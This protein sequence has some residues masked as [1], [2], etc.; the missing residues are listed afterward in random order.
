MLQPIL[1]KN[2]SGYEGA[3]LNEIYA[4]CL[5]SLYVFEENPSI[6]WEQWQPYIERAIKMYEELQMT[7]RAIRCH[8]FL[9]D[10]QFDQAN[11]E[12]VIEIIDGMTPQLSVMDSI[13]TKSVYIQ[14]MAMKSFALESLGR[15]QQAHAELDA[16]LQFSRDHIVL[17][18]YYWLLNT[19]AWLYYDEHNYE[20]A[21]LL[22][23]EAKPFIQ[24]VNHEGI[25]ME[26]ELTNIFLTRVFRTQL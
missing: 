9:A 10:V 8:S 22:I 14:Q 12:L 6:T 4:K 20:N 24:L 7:W 23:K 17:D 3:R 25:E 1:S 13:E 2:P 26:F 11:Y 5:Y 16:D 21:R 15:H 18:N 19:K